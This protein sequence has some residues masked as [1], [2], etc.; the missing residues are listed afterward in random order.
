MA[1]LTQLVLSWKPC[2]SSGSGYSTLVVVLA[3][4]VVLLWYYSVCYMFFTSGQ[5]DTVGVVV[6]ALW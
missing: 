4:I 6:E 2:S 5:H 1:V 3:V